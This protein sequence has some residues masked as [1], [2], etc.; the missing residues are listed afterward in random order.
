MNSENLVSSDFKKSKSACVVDLRFLKKLK[1]LLHFQSG[2]TMNMDIVIKYFNQLIQF[3]PKIMKLSKYSVNNTLF[4]IIGKTKI[5][6]FL[7]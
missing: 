2:M 6:K 3:Y 1:K 5:I 4:K 7:K